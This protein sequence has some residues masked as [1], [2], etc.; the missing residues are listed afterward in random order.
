M[1][2][3]TK[4]MRQPKPGLTMGDSVVEQV[5]KYLRRLRYT[6]PFPCAPEDA[7]FGCVPP[8]I[9]EW[10]D[11]GFFSEEAPL[12]GRASNLLHTMFATKRQ[13]FT[14][15]L[16]LGD[17]VNVSLE[18][19]DEYCDAI[20]GARG[21]ERIIWFRVPAHVPLP[22]NS[23][24]TPFFLPLD[25]PQRTVILKWEEEARTLEESITG[26]LR[27]VHEVDMLI[28]SAHLQIVWPELLHFV[29]VSSPMRAVSHAQWRPSLIAAARRIS[30]RWR[31]LT[32]DMLSTAAILPEKS[33]PLVGWVHFHS[34]AIG[35]GDGLAE[36]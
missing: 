34:A 8:S 3:P 27:K 12:P 2:L 24:E 28:E 1:K 18:S 33:E 20:R 22:R 29:K 19:Q 13:N 32:T 7:Y 36:T 25:H 5:E 6:L 35:D 11:K 9:R 23:A 17:V 15:Q 14:A 21:H 31:T 4:R 30:P 26:V 16:Q 10:H